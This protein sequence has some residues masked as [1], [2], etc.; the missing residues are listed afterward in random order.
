M[1][2]AHS[3]AYVDVD[4]LPYGP[5]KFVHTGTTQEALDDLSRREDALVAGLARKA[6]PPLLSLL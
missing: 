3:D 4:L 6:V 2:N 1:F 5:A